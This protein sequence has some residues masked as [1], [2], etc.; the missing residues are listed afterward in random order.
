MSVAQST[1]NE[2]MLDDAQKNYYQY[3]KSTISRLPTQR[4]QLQKH[5]SSGELVEHFLHT[6]P[7]IATGHVSY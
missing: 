1:A 6:L 4:E 7:D 5:A 3:T 2:H